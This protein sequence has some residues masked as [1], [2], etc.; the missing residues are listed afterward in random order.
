MARK[1]SED[2]NA[3]FDETSPEELQALKEAGWQISDDGIQE[4]DEPQPQQ[5]RPDE[6]DESAFEPEDD[7]LD[8]DSEALDDEPEPEDRKPKRR[9]RPRGKRGKGQTDAGQAELE[10]LRAENEQLRA[11]SASTQVTSYQSQVTAHLS[12]KQQEV[13]ALSQQMVEALET[14]ETAK[15]VELQ[16]KLNAAQLEE[17][18]LRN[19]QAQADQQAQALAQQAQQPPQHPAQ[20]I[21][22][23]AMADFMDGISDWYGQDEAASQHLQRIDNALAAEGTFA[24]GSQAYFDEL[25]RRAAIAL[26]NHFDRQRVEEYAD[27]EPPR[28]QKRQSDVLPPSGESPP[29]RRSRQGNPRLSAEDKRAM[30]LW[31]YDPR[32]EKSARSWKAAKRLAGQE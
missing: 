13:E 9:R 11:H 20:S 28:R 32:D 27:N 1:E 8:S 18:Q 4:P 7:D 12:A 19:A 25:E 15:H 22:Q 30:A 6:Q 26:P 14:G 24:Y 17:H 10:R 5:D 23:E 31:G 16:R 21:D 29:S 3:V 2:G